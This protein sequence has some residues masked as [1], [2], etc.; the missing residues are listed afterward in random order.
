MHSPLGERCIVPCGAEI[1]TAITV[2]IE[3]N[4]QSLISVSLLLLIA[5]P[6]TLFIFIVCVD[7][8]IFLHGFVQLSGQQ[9]LLLLYFIN[10]F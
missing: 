2:P 1:F 7:L 10:T 5:L 3:D 9:L 4:A 6:S 8:F